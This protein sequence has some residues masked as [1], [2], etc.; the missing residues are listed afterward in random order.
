MPSPALG[1]FERLVHQRLDKQQGLFEEEEGAD[2]RDQRET[3]D[4]QHTIRLLRVSISSN[5][6]K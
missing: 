2:R 4:L 1:S 6:G 5:F 3:D